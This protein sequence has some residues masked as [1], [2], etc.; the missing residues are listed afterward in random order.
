MATYNKLSIG[1]S[2]EEV[3][4]LQNALM[5]AGYDVGSSG[6]DGKFGPSTSAAVKKYQK[7]MG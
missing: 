5:S 3:R 7:D 6:A 2:G 1:S 4:K